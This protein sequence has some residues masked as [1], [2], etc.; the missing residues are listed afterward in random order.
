MSKK[1]RDREKVFKKVKSLLQKNDAFKAIE[2]LNGS[3]DPLTIAKRYSELVLDFYWKERSLSHVIPFSISGIQYCLTKAEG[4]SSKK[5]AKEL[6]GIAKAISYN[7]ASFTWPGWN[8][9]GIR[10]TPVEIEIGLD[11]AKFNLRLARELKKGEIPQI[12]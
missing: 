12:G 1:N 2:F 11:S 7:L 10:I 9:K 5:V 6:K 4:S 3:G 8:E